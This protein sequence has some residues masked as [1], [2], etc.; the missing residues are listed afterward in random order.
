MWP[1]P[2]VVMGSWHLQPSKPSRTAASAAPFLMAVPGE[3]GCGHQ[4]GGH[5]GLSGDGFRLS[6]VFASRL[7]SQG[8]GVDF[9]S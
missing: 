4:A 7:L 1:M 8:G 3:R 6:C 2:A 5:N 9:P